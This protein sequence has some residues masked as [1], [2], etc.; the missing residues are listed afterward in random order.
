[1]AGG[2]SGVAGRL[3]LR[4]PHRLPPLG[5]PYAPQCD[6]SGNPAVGLT[7]WDAATATCGGCR[8]GCAACGGRHVPFRGLR[9]QL[10]AT[11]WSLLCTA[12][13]RAAL[14][15]L[16]PVS[17]VC[18][19]GFRRS[20]LK[21]ACIPACH[22]ATQFLNATDDCAVCPAPATGLGAGMG[23]NRTCSESD[24]GAFRRGSSWAR[25]GGRKIDKHTPNKDPPTRHHPGPAFQ[26]A[27]STEGGTQLLVPALSAAV[28]RPR[29]ALQLWRRF[30]RG[31]C[32]ASQRNHNAH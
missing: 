23:F 26:T 12:S 29:G 9:C 31:L 14:P 21:Q 22:L 1:V 16:P 11:R 5:P 4:P 10:G 24:Q 32:K 7:A 13:P 15:T 30:R 2:G 17:A 18:G 28:R 20:E 6:C 25:G 27:P 3:V 8:D 19:A